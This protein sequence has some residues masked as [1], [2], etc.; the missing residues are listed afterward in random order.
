[1]YP[2]HKYVGCGNDFI[3]FDNQ[4]LNFP[5]TNLKLI[6]KLCCRHWGIGA[7]G[8]LLLEPSLQADARMRIFNAD[9]SEAEMCGNG[10]RC[11]AARLHALNVNQ[12]SFCIETMHRLIKVHIKN[13]HIYVE[14][15]APQN[16]RW[17][18]KIKCLDRIVEVDYLDTGVPHIVLFVDQIEKVDMSL[19]G[20]TLRNH[21]AWGA[22]GANVNFVQVL[23]NNQIKLRT[24]ERGIEGETLACGTGATAAALS[25]AYKKKMSPPITV[26]TKLNEKLVISF[27]LKNQVF[28]E[29]EMAG[30]VQSVFK[31]EIHLTNFI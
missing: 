1:M 11:F 26:K 20:P 10:I 24:Y 12:S 23:P 7:D 27:L 22:K 31:G 8:I 5:H 25:T 4:D 21:E 16:I 14:M 15:G 17:N 9:G 3:L 30:S 28:S 2:F 19:L 29:V 6:Q 13:S 18:Q